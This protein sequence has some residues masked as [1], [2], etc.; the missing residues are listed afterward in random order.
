MA[1]HLHY[2]DPRWDL[3]DPHDYE[4][5]PYTVEPNYWNQETSNQEDT[6]RY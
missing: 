5:D 2:Q 3:A 6:W 1:N 4:I